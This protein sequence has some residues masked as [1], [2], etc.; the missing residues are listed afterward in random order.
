LLSIILTGW[1]AV[2]HSHGCGCKASFYNSLLPAISN[3]LHDEQTG[4]ADPALNQA[5]QTLWQ[6]IIV[7]GYATRTANTDKAVRSL[8]GPLQ[9]YIEKRIVDNMDGTRDPK[10]MKPLWIIHTPQ[11]PTPLVTEGRIN[12]QLIS[13]EVIDDKDHT[14]LNTA[15]ARAKTLQAYLEKGGMLVVV[16]QDTPAHDG[17]R[18]KEQQ[19]YYQKLKK[20]YAAQIID[21]PVAH[22][23]QNLTGATYF[24]P[25]KNGVFEMTNRGVQ[26]THDSKEA[27]WGVWLQER[28]RAKPVVSAQIQTLFTFLEQAGL[29]TKLADHAKQHGRAPE[30]FFGLG[31]HYALSTLN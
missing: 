23:P 26:I 19:R 20:R 28:E 14:R 4:I 11:I 16:Y 18:S 25:Q 9:F 24:V 30:V 13:K 29:Q 1:I 15:L 27:T 10:A 2:A 7:K 5:A 12:Q 21:F 22:F 8:F 17:G 6:E 3:D 31:N